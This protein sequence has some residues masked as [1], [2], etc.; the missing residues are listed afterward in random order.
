MSLAQ[1]VCNIARRQVPED[2]VEQ[3]VT[4]GLEVGDDAG[5]EADN[6]VFWLEM[7]L[8][9]PPFKAARPVVERVEGN[10]FRVAYLE[11]NDDRPDD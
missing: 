11:V 1:E 7:L 3:I 9:T 8:A 6:L 2:Q 4:V 5:V 10:V